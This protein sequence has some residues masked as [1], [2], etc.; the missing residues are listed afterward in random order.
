MAAMMTIALT[1][2][3]FVLGFAVGVQTERRR[4]PNG[5]LYRWDMA[6]A[7]YGEHVATRRMRECDEAHYPGDCPLCGAEGA[8]R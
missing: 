8:N 3:V 5:N 4:K 1:L 6:K 7:I 2:V